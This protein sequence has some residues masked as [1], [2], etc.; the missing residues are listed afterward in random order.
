MV[1]DVA[2]DGDGVVFAGVVACV[3]VDLANVELHGSLVLS[4]DE[5]VGPGAAEHRRAFNEPQVT[6]PAMVVRRRPKVGSRDPSVAAEAHS[7][8]LRPGIEE[9]V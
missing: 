9:R 5:L 8:R 3:R 7:R 4:L 6:V 2:G 1:A